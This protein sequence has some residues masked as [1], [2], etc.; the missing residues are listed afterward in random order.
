M[1]EV[2]PCKIWDILKL[3]V[4]YYLFEIQIYLVYFFFNLETLSGS[5][6]LSSGTSLH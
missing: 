2:I 3:K 5:Q 1:E 4:M 6:G